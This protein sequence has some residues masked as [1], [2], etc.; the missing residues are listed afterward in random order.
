LG[1]LSTLLGL[2]GCKIPAHTTS[3]IQNK[4]VFVTAQLNHLLMP[5]ECGER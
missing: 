5:I 3:Q 4:E 2:G 1:I